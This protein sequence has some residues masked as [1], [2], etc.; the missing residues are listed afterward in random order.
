MDGRNCSVFETFNF[1]ERS[2]SKLY[3][4]RTLNEDLKN[5]S[6]I[7]KKADIFEFTYLMITFFSITTSNNMFLKLVLLIYIVQFK[8][9]L[10][11]DLFGIEIIKYALNF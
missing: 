10:K 5:T 9:Y 3:Y 8:S 4:F 11:L 6:I 2:F 1:A 7:P